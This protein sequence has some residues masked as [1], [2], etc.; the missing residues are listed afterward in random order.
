MYLDDNPDYQT[1]WK[2]AHNWVDANP[3]E[4]DT[5]AIP[6]K[7]REHIIRLIL[8]I[9]NKDIAARTRKGVIFADNSIIT[10]F[11]NIPH[12]INTRTCLL[13][14]NFNKSYLDSL[15]VKREEVINLCIKSYCDFPPCWVPNRLPFDQAIAKDTKNY[16][17]ADEIED[18]IRCQAIASALWE[19]E[20]DIHPVHIARSKIMQRFGN[21][22]TY[23]EETIKEWIKEVDP[24][25][26]RKKGAPL[27][28][29][30]H[31][32]LIKD[33]KLED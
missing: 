16:R 30:Y 1:V 33:P 23:G 9:R 8:A 26:K 32:N 17:P 4:T 19:L 11:E 10:I 25:K 22:R 18:R 31:I 3:D 6:P 20:P 7:L 15:Y 12:Y 28:K 21:G 13:N 5:N 29:K 27:K 24:I 2:L 14:G